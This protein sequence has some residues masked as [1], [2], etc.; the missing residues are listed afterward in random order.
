MKI[1]QFIRGF[2]NNIF[3]FCKLKLQGNLSIFNFQS[4]GTRQVGAKKQSA[5]QHRD[6]HGRTDGRMYG[7]TYTWAPCVKP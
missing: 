4:A 2:Q 1:A 7:R 3:K 6:V 5:N